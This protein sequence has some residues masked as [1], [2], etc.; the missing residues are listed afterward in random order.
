MGGTTVAIPLFKPDCF[1]LLAM[2]V[3]LMLGIFIAGCSAPANINIPSVPKDHSAN[4][5]YQAAQTGMLSDRVC[6]DDQGDPSIPMGKIAEGE[7][8]KKF[9][10]LTAGV[11]RF[12]ETATGK[13]YLGVS[14]LQ[15][16]GL[17]QIPKV[18]AWEEPRI[19]DQG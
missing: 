3:F 9:P 1:A 5:F 11:F 13:N 2:T 6:Q 4:K 12:Q 8:Y 10:D 19:R 18:C 17:L 15:Y 7:G 14:F 16:N